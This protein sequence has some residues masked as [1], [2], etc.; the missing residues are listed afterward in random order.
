VCRIAVTAAAATITA[1]APPAKGST[2]QVRF[3]GRTAGVLGGGS[4]CAVPPRYG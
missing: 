1:S 4:A 3:T 2:H